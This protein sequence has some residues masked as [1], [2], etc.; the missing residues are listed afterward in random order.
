MCDKS[1]LPSSGRGQSPG[2][3]KMQS[4][5]PLGLSETLNLPLP[6]LHSTRQCHLLLDAFNSTEREL[7]V[8]ARGNEEL[9]LHAGECQR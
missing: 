7:T 8:S 2:K 6:F 3:R 1:L 5:P 9:T 4:L